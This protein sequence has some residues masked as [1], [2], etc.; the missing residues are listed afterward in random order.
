MIKISAI[1][2]LFVFTI[3]SCQQKESKTVVNENA[4]SSALPSP[5][6]VPF[7]DD[8]TD[9]RIAQLQ[10]KWISKDDKKSVVEFQVRKKIEVYDGEKLGE[11]Q[12][13][14]KKDTLESYEAGQPDTMRYIIDKLTAEDLNLIYL[15]RGNMLRYTKAK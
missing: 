1:V 14:L 3:I 11:F 2:I 15:E 13:A 8:A 6:P 7:E 9:A 4:D 12:F 5:L 10:G